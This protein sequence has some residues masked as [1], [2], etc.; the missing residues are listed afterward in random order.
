VVSHA[1]HH[2]GCKVKIFAGQK[3]ITISLTSSSELISGRQTDGETGDLISLP[4]F[5]ESRLTRSSGKN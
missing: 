4:S 5:L 2:F 1:A 3:L